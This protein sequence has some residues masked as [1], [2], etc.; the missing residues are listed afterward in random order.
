[1]GQI[2]IFRH[3]SDF[4]AAI[5]YFFIEKEPIIK[6]VNPQISEQYGN[7]FITQISG[8]EKCPD[9]IKTRLS[10]S[11]DNYFRYNQGLARS[12]I[13]ALELLTSGLY[14]VYESQMHPSNGNGKFFWNCYNYTEELHG[15]SDKNPVIGDS[16]FCPTFLIP[17]HQPISFQI[18]KLSHTIKSDRKLY[19][20]AYHITGMFSA[21]LEGHH[22]ATASLIKDESFRC[23]VI[24]PLTDII[25][26]SEERNKN[27]KIVALACANARIPVEQLPD[28]SLERFLIWRK[29]VKPASFDEL[30]PKLGKTILPVSKKSFPLSLYDKAL[31]LPDCDLIES[32]SGVK[33]LTKEQISTLLNGEVKHGDEIII[34]ANLHSSLVSAANYLQ[35]TDFDM[36]MDFTI[37]ILKRSELESAHKYIAERLLTVMHPKINEFFA[38]IVAEKEPTEGIIAETAPK[39]IEK[40]EQYFN[41]KQEY[42]LNH[43]R[44]RQKKTDSMKAIA[45]AKGIATL[46]AAVRDIGGMTKF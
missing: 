22:L 15:T 36:F 37:N 17:T 24:E 45:E 13:S 18:K 34:S 26:D 7:K 41:K 35:I 3:V 43:A 1:M 4:R 12:A 40:W 23:L 44:E 39:Y 38:K 16:C 31:Q 30:K 20:V 32:A 28:N 11:A 2:G 5:D 42:E 8:S 19:G 46:E 10:A 25:Y 14:V 21:L 33:H 27:R 6:I 9:Y 29:H